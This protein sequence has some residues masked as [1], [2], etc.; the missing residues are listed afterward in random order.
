MFELN[1]FV[2][3]GVDGVCK[4]SG[5]TVRQMRGK[6]VE[7]YVLE[8]CSSQTTTIYVPIDNQQL[9][10]RMRKVLNQNEALALIRSMPDEQTIWIEDDNHRAEVY[11]RILK[12]E[13]RTEL[14][15]LIK[16][17]YLRKQEL[18]TQKRKL[19]ASDE[20]L[21]H[22]AERRLHEELSHAL[23]I[24]QEDVLPFIYGQF[25]DKSRAIM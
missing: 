21:L 20:K 2:L 7:Y 11:A 4:V 15:R 1:D 14:I 5:K 24:R 8:S 22:E 9:V 12:G 18:T 3:Y 13:D 23:D 17:L 19:R 16:T 10:A 6:R 25:T